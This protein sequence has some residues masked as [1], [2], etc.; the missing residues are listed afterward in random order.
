MSNDPSAPARKEWVKASYSPN[1]TTVTVSLQQGNASAKATVKA[2]STGIPKGVAE[3]RGIAG[4]ML[5]DL[6]EAIG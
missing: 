5:D 4:R 3:A 2:Y 1:G 6:L